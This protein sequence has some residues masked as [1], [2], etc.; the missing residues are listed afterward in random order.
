[1]LGP[2]KWCPAT[3][4][5]DEIRTIVWKMKLFVT[6]QTSVRSIGNLPNLKC[7][8]LVSGHAR[9]VKDLKIVIGRILPLLKGRTYSLYVF[10]MPNIGRGFEPDQKFMVHSLNHLTQD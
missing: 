8:P 6:P 7:G 4:R 2:D 9:T 1:M 10:G 3:K 5:H